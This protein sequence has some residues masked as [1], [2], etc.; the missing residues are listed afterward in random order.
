M[1]KLNQL[2]SDLKEKDDK[3]LYLFNCGL[4]YNFINTDAEIMSHILRL[5]LS[6]LNKTTLKCGFPTSSLKKYLY[7]LDSTTYKYEVIDFSTY[8][9]YLPKQ[10]VLNEKIIL[11]LNELSNIDSDSLSISEVYEFINN[12]KNKAELLR[13]EL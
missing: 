10:Y 8:K 6:H 7:L 4:F 13:K 12:F 3:T 1:S 9:T 2:Y 11:F 5:K